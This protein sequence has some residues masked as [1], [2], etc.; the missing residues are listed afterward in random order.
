MISSLGCSEFT[1]S[2]FK[3]LQ[4]TIIMDDYNLSRQNTKGKRNGMFKDLPQLD[5]HVIIFFLYSINLRTKDLKRWMCPSVISHLPYSFFW[6]ISHSTQLAQQT[7]CGTLSLEKQS[8]FFQKDS[9]RAFRKQPQKGIYSSVL[10]IKNYLVFLI[11][12]YLPG[13]GLVLLQYSW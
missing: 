6:N 11:P 3:C 13:V 1:S 12:Q 8:L 4:Y 7:K 9:R 5:L 2:P 10:E